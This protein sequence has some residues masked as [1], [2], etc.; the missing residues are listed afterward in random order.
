MRSLDI[1]YI[2]NLQGKKR[3]KEDQL[4]SER[5]FTNLNKEYNGS[6]LVNTYSMTIHFYLFSCSMADFKG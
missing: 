5:Q 6:L 2:L 4:N 1:G 3:K